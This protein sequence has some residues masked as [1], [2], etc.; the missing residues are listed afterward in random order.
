MATTKIEDHYHVYL[1]K[2]ADSF[3]TTHPQTLYIYM[4]PTQIYD[5]AVTSKISTTKVN[6]WNINVD[7]YEEPYYDRYY[8]AKTDVFP[9]NIKKYYERIS[10]PYYFTDSMYAIL[11]IAYCYR[12]TCPAEYVT[13]ITNKIAESVSD[14]DIKALMLKKGYTNTDVQ[15]WI[16]AIKIFLT[17]FT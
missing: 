7:S 17:T 14:T 8:P 10:F 12:Y 13:F 9:N 1:Y 5:V 11:L 15:N 3:I 2:P 16:D 6:E 4:K